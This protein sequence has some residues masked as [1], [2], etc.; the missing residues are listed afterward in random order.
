[1]GMTFL[2]RTFFCGEAQ[3][4]ERHVAQAAQ[5][6]ANPAS[7]KSALVHCDVAHVENAVLNGP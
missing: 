4:R 2:L 7:V 3:Q 1:M 6:R 5:S